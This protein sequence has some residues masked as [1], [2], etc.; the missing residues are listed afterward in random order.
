MKAYW[1]HTG[2]AGE[3]AAVKNIDFTSSKKLEKISKEKVGGTSTITGGKDISEASAGEMKCFLQNLRDNEQER[4]LFLVVKPFC[5]EIA[6]INAVEN[7]MSKFYHEKYKGEDLN[8]LL[9]IEK[10]I[11]MTLSKKN[12]IE[13]DIITRKKAKCTAWFHHR[14]GR[15]TAS[16]FRA[17]IA[18]SLEAPSISLIKKIC[19]PTVTYFKS[20]AMKYGCNHEKEAGKRFLVKMKNKHTNLTVSD[21]GLLI[22]PNYPEVGATSFSNLS[23]E[24]LQI[25][26][27]LSNLD[28]NLY[29]GIPFLQQYRNLQQHKTAIYISIFTVY[30]PLTAD[31]A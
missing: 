18:T 24:I 3:P 2:T 27:R 20:A 9:K 29:I 8:T 26:P 17:C 31:D 5:D 28:G 15:V 4:A 19:Y 16:N 10:N 30:S 23:L 1:K 6:H 14:L 25:R 22:N 12:C 7:P 11:D 21:V 13:I